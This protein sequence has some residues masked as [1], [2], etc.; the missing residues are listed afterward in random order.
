MRRIGLT[1]SVVLFA[2]LFTAET[3]AIGPKF[4][5]SPRV[6]KDVIEKCYLDGVNSDNEGVRASAATFLGYL[7]SKEAV[8]PL[9]KMMRDEK[10]EDSRI[11]AALALIRIGD[12]QGVYM[13]GR[14]S[15]YNSSDRVKRIAEKF[16]NQFTFG[17]VEETP[18]YPIYSN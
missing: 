1:L 9:M 12:A 4:F 10:S 15:L 17:T 6:A 11:I 7:K 5:T 16:Y 18:L 8:L 3:F 14:T 2:L 13:V